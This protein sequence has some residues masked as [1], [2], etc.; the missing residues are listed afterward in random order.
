MIVYLVLINLSFMKMVHVD[1]FN[2]Y[3][4]LLKINAYKNNLILFI[5]DMKFLKNI[6]AQKIVNIV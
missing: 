5:M 2:N 4:M 1:V 3:T 6:F